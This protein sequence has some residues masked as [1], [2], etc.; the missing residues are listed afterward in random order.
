MSEN[1]FNIT[2]TRERLSVRFKNLSL[3]E[4]YPISSESFKG[5]VTELRK[6]LQMFSCLLEKCPGCFTF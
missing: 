1:C 2:F 3:Y 4:T 6:L 5:T